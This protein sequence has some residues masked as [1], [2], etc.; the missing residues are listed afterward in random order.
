MLYFVAFAD[1]FFSR[2]G[3]SR[4]ATKTV[5]VPEPSIG[6]KANGKRPTEGDLPSKMKS[7]ARREH[8][9]TLGGGVLETD[10]SKES[11]P[12]TPK[13]PTEEVPEASSPVGET[14]KKGPTKVPKDP[15]EDFMVPPA[16]TPNG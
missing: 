13:T 11:V 14:R 5:P 9:V 1:D 16:G 7:H 12:P 3:P 15:L 10:F 4:P 6:H 2:L 8:G